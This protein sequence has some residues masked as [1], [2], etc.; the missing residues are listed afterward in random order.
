MYVLFT[1]YILCHF[2]HIHHAESAS[3]LYTVW[4]LIRNRP[5]WMRWKAKLS[6]LTYVQ[7]WD[8]KC[9]NKTV[10]TTCMNKKDITRIH[11][12]LSVIFTVEVI[13]SCVLAWTNSCTSSILSFSLFF[14]GAEP[15]GVNPLPITEAFWGWA[16]EPF[17]N[18]EFYLG[19]G[20]VK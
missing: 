19:F 11:L 3:T 4:G 10:K 20:R 17:H 15:N 7:G 2:L 6:S 1:Y 18:W 8:S 12:A 9:P 13:K 5:I 16:V 14:H